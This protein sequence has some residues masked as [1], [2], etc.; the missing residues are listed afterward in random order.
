MDLSRLER[1]LDDIQHQPG[2]RGEADKGCDYYDGKQLDAETIAALRRRNLGELSQNLIKPT[3][4]AVLGLEAKTRTDWMVTCEDD[5]WQDV[6][7]AM[8]TKIKEA[9]RE[10]RADRACSDAHAG[11]IKAGFHVV[12]VS[13]TTNPFDYPY[14]VLPVHRREI[15]WDWHSLHPT[16]DDARYL[17]RKR[18]LD[19]DVT[20][21]FFPESKELIMHAAHGWAGTWASTFDFDNRVHQLL[22]SGQEIENRTRIEDMEWRN[23]ERNRVCVFEVW[24]R[25]YHRGAVLWLPDGRKVE[26]DAKNPMHVAAVASGMVQPRVGVFDRLRLA[27]FVGPHRVMDV[28][29][30]RRRF[31]YVPFWGYREDLTGAPYGLIRS[32]LSP[33]DEVNARRAKMMWLLSAKRI[34]IDADALDPKYNTLTAAS[35]ELARADSFLVLNQNRVNKDGVRVD[36]NMELAD[37]QFQLL[38]EA[39]TA[40]QE[41]GGIYAA[42]MGQNSNATSGTAIQSLIEQGTM[43]LAEINDNYYFARRHVGESLLELIREDMKT[44]IDVMVE[45]GFTKKQVTV[46]KPMVDPETQMPYLENDVSRAPLK[47]ALTDVPSTPS[48][49]AQQFTQLAEIT[50]SLPP[51]LQAFVAPFIIEASE[52]SR[53]KELAALMRKQL[54]IEGDPNSPEAQAAMQEQMAKQQQLEELGMQELMAKIKEINARGDKSMADAEKVRSEI[55]AGDGQA[56]AQ[57]NTEMQKLRDESLKLQNEIVLL[58]ASQAGEAMSAQVKAEADVEKA[59][60]TAEGQERVAQIEQEV[61]LEVARINA[62]AEKKIDA[63]MQKMTELEAKFAEQLRKV[64]QDAKD[65]ESKA[66]EDKA[67]EDADRAKKDADD[68]AKAADEKKKDAEAKAKDDD[69]KGDDKPQQPMVVVVPG[70]GGKGKRQIKF[71]SDDKGNLIGADIEEAE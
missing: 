26:Y 35:Q 46:N 7:D 42:M 12:E 63:V 34:L 38:M 61:E 37:K 47:V 30:T 64:E 55:G 59:R 39:K 31:P 23:T 40:V 17:V 56:N 20:A 36:E 66:R 3:I 2:W 16:W 1:L 48:F 58:K 41:A 44:Q 27:Y 65:R 19:A 60:L 50:K 33:Q 18:W 25:T 45:R 6:S 9:E 4:D 49:R 8:N 15:Y 32:M 21:A 11:Q 53:R 29:S 24:Y 14:R 43:T 28:A 71:K 67:R 68:K 62:E 57:I 22:L 13:R 69:K 54:G 51:Q 5:R 10:T 70:G 52:L